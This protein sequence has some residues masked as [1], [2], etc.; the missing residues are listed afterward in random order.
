MLFVC[1]CFQKVTVVS[2]KVFDVFRISEYFGFFLQGCDNDDKIPVVS[3][4]FLSPLPSL[5]K[6][7]HNSLA[8]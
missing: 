2:Y 1:T 8:R 4:E 7:L 5:S 6:T 3:K